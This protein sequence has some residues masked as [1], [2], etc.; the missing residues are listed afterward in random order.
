MNSTP[1]EY[2]PWDFYLF[3]VVDGKA[4]FRIPRD[5]P[6]VRPPTEVD[7]RQGGSP[8]NQDELAPRYHTEPDG[9]QLKGAVTSSKAIGPTGL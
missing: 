2:R 8:V 7:L 5:L 1:L 9:A 3:Q 4:D 6:E